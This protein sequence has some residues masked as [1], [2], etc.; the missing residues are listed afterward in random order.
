MKMVTRGES[1]SRG[2][3][4][5]MHSRDSVQIQTCCVFALHISTAYIK[6]KREE[7]VFFF[8]LFT[9]HAYS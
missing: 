7:S 8:R 9:S 4:L 3:K 5:Q 1:G 6:L 2:N